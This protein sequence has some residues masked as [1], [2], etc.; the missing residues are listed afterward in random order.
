MP[1]SEPN[2]QIPGVQLSD[3]LGRGSF[4]AVYRGHHLTLDVD[5]AVKFINDSAGDAAILERALY[6]ARLMA[7]L[8]H[9]N[10]L[11]IYDAR[12]SDSMIYLVLELMDGGSCAGLRRLTPDDAMHL[13][14]QLLS[15]LQALHEARILHRD[16]KPAN[17]LRRKQDGRI[18]LADL[19]IA[20]EQATQTDKVYDSAGTVP[21]MAPELFDRPP[22]FSPSSDL[23][24]LGLT[25]TSMCLGADPFPKSSFAELYAWITSKERPKISAVR[26][27]LPTPLTC[28]LQRLISP[29][30]ADRLASAAE[31]IALLNEPSPQRLDN[32]TVKQSEDTQS[33]AATAATVGA[34]VLGAQVYAS[35]NWRGYAA[36]HYLSGIPARIMFLQP[37]GPLA[38]SSVL[39][40]ASAERAARLNHPAVLD[41]LDWGLKDER[42]YVVT[43]PQGIC[44]DELIK[45][46]GA[47][48]ELEA[49][50]ITASVADALTYLHSRGLVYQMV[51]PGAIVVSADA[52]SAQLSWPVFCVP[53]GTPGKDEHGTPHRVCVAMYA[54]PEAFFQQ[55]SQGTIE[56]ATDIYGLG[57]VLYYLLAGKSAHETGAKNVKEADVRDV[58]PHVTAPTARLIKELTHYDPAQRP[59]RAANVKDELTRI[60]QRLRGSGQPWSL[61]E[62]NSINREKTS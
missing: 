18:K 5:V 26:R 61:P 46:S 41:V 31:A 1:P 49:V 58:A 44:I 3:E 13:T 39:I 16:I 19:G 11:R 57:E 25:I 29:D 15:G 28:L 50:E 62:S 21:F 4:G 56:P 55:S 8:D 2:Y 54:A 20:V 59:A 27:D 32:T 33:V 30:V 60:A 24:A 37:T 35:S 14:R 7:R 38:N 52:R 53:A 51:E 9:P 34:W 47:C 22:R 12:R 23:Y 17:C 48:D 10:L 45:A 42:A 6:E 36:T 40:L 43:A